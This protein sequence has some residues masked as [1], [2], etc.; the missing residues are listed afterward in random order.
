MAAARRV[1][2]LAGLVA[3]AALAFLILIWVGQRR[4]IYIPL[5]RPGSP[6]AVG[7]PGA[8]EVS[9]PTADGLTLGAW[10]VPAARPTAGFTVL[11]FPGNAGNRS[12]RAPLAAALSDAG[13]SVLLVDYRGYGGN[14]GSPS[15]EGLAADALGALGHLEAR[16][17]VDA[18]RIVYFG[19][20]LGT[21]VA[22]TLAR[23]HP[24]AALILRSPFTSLV[25]L[26]RLH[27]P[28]LPVAW[29][30]RER[31]P[32]MD[33]IGALTCPLL[34]LAGDRDRIIPLEQSRRLF[35]AAPEP[36]RFVTI[37][38]ARHND[39]ALLAGDRLLHEVVGFLETTEAAQ[40]RS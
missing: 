34:V 11:F 6:S 40:P 15:E 17:D 33:R 27:Y 25:E 26:G 9:F 18:E 24:P 23:E 28:F 39:L 30:L 10:F 36:K 13:L 35:Q 21:G 22:V 20:S 2:G 4:L 38:G 5:G 7:L 32:S 12:F 3:A 14:P 1:M 8:R 19:E 31:Y 37:P 16:G 29:F